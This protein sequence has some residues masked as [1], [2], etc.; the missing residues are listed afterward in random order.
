MQ[1]SQHPPDVD[2]DP[3]PSPSLFDSNLWAHSQAQRRSNSNSALKFSLSIWCSGR[4]KFKAAVEQ[5][6]TP[7]WRFW[8]FTQIESPASWG[9]RWVKDEHPEAGTTHAIRE[10]Q[11]AKKSYKHKGFELFSHTKWH[12]SSSARSLWRKILIRTAWIP[13]IFSPW[14]NPTAWRTPWKS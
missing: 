5:A 14:I 8:T 11:P 12:N 3:L 4:D 6:M 1:S 13:K 7:L 2:A 10:S 9:W